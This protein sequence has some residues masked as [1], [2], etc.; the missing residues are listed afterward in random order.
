MRTLRLMAYGFWLECQFLRERFS[1]RKLRQ[2]SFM[3][4]AFFVATWTLIIADRFNN[5][6]LFEKWGDV[7]FIGV[8]WIV[9]TF[10]VYA[11]H[12][13]YFLKNFPKKLTPTL[14]ER[15]DYTSP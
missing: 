6:I 11:D 3:M 1:T 5:V 8:M 14:H 4:Y 15:T 7:L 12:R 9:S 10:G 2:E 13:E